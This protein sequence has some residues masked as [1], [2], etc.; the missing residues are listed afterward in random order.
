MDS[1]IQI[2]QWLLNLMGIQ[3]CIY[4]R[5]RVPQDTAVIVVSNH[6]SF[7]DPLV[8]MKALNHSVR[9]ACHHYM[10]Q[11]PGMRDVVQA[12]GGFPL[13]EPEKRQR[14]FFRQ[15]TELLQQQEWVVIFPEGAQ[16]MVRLTHPGEV[17]KFE[18]GFAHLALRS[19]VKNLAVLPVAIATLAEAVTH[20]MPLQMLRLFDPSEP[21]FDQGGWHPMVTYEKTDILI[22]RPY[23]ITPQK[24]EDYQGKQAKAV[25]K[26]LT[27]YCRTEIVTLLECSSVHR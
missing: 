27:D 4:H 10:G 12:L 24:R 5:D 16:P 20:I 6:R 8:L 21:L 26:D 9:T 18:R 14:A 3:M 17:G 2:S 11:V 19:E 1:P 15:A 23:W 25:V 22:G 13:A 7:M